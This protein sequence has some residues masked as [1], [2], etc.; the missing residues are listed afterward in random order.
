M[1]PPTEEPSWLDIM[2]GR[3]EGASTKVRILHG[4][5]QS[6]TRQGVSDTT[7]QD[8]LK[9]AGVSRRTFYQLFRSKEDLL[10]ALYD[11]ATEILVRTLQVVLESPAPARQRIEDAIT[12]YLELQQ[13]GGR[14]AVLL[15]TEAIRPES[16]LAPRR[17]WVYDQLIA[18]FEEPVRQ[19]TGDR[20]PP[21]AIRGVLL[22]VEGLIIHAQK[23]GSLSDEDRDELERTLSLLTERLLVG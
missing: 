23:K 1:P 8:V 2:Q 12:A 17:E 6:F 4:A 11:A 21:L 3:V 16:L 20:L 5:L 10:S 14:L 13:Q 22:A 7:V 15:Q 19:A 18:L 9:D